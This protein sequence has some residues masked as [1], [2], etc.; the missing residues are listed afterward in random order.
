MPHVLALR[1]V[2]LTAILFWFPRPV[3]STP[4]D[5]ERILLNSLLSPHTRPTNPQIP[6][7]TP[8]EIALLLLLT[9]GGESG[10]SFGLC[11]GFKV[12]WELIPDWC[13]CNGIRFEM[14]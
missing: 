12:Y 5:L 2:I 14:A 13:K 7:P 8:T 1:R 9:S 3:T 11:F 6:T 4:M 10:Q